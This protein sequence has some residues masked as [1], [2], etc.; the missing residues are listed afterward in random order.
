MTKPRGVD[1]LVQVSTK[2][3][4]SSWVDVTDLINFDFRSL[5][6]GF[7]LL[8]HFILMCIIFVILGIVKFFNI[9][10]FGQPDHKEMILECNTGKG[11]K[12]LSTCAMFLLPQKLAIKSETQFLLLLLGAFVAIVCLL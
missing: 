1:Q 9:D 2:E 5:P 12:I 11:F 8:G 6:T 4:R 7:Y 3:A 10:I